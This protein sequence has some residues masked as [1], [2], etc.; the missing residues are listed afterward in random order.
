MPVR[1]T[2]FNNIRI[3]ENQNPFFCGKNLNEVYNLH[4]DSI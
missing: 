1:A 4:K 3:I 2:D